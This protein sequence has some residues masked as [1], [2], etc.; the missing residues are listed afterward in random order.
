MI[1]ICKLNENTHILLKSKLSMVRN[2]QTS[3]FDALFIK[4]IGNS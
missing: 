1:D 4:L 3:E 2:Q